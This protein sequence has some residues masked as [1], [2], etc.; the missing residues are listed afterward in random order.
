MFQHAIVRAPGE[1]FAD[2]LTTS[3]LGKPDFS[4][5][6]T[7]HAAYCDAL[8]QCGLHLVRLDADLEHPDSTFV[9]DTAVLTAK[10][11]ILARPGA[12]SRLGEV[13]AI[14]KT[15]ERFYSTIHKIETPGTLDGGDICEAGSHFFI[16]VSHRTNE[17]GARQLG[18]FL[19]AEGYRSSVVDIRSMTSILHLKSGIAYLDKNNFVVMEELADRKEFAG[20]SLVRVPAEESY[21]CNCVL[22]NDRVLLPSG[23]PRLN[24]ALTGLG[25]KP[26]LLDMSEFRKMDGGLSCLSLRF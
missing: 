15:V 5:V 8:K 16:G 25:Y 18:E 3:D 6:L 24:A 7:Q 9:E 20:Y 12:S 26:L 23:F 1:N 2:G 19:A 21:A 17:E 13:A 22:V 11:A 10:S 14:R 4:K